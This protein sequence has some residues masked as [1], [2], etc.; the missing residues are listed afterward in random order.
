MSDF[1]HQTDKDVEVLNGWFWM[2]RRTALERVGLLDEQFFM[3]G[4]DIDWSYR[5][6]QSGLRVVFFSR[7]GAVHY[8]GASSSSAP[9][10][11]AVEQ[12][13]ANM[14][15]FKKH[16]G[17]IAYSGFFVTAVLYCSIRAIGYGILFV[18]SSSSRAQRHLKLDRS[19]AGLKLLWGSIGLSL[20]NLKRLFI[21][22][23]SCG[24]FLKD[25]VWD[26]ALRVVGKQPP[27]ICVV[28]RYHGIL[29]RTACKFRSSD[30]CCN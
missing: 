1:N 22:L 18:F 2:V 16:N 7:T 11:F 28:L 21:F 17:K 9:V 23:V 10:F 30:G 24:Y 29:N 15:L 8:G 19:I 4:E 13:R 6:H 3:Y 20:R 5:F 25:R 27:G 14:Q 26:F 12:Q